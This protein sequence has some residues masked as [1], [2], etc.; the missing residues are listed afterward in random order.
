M[1][2]ILSRHEWWLLVVW[3]LWRDWSH[4]ASLL[5]IFKTILVFR[6]IIKLNRGSKF[7]SFWHRLCLELHNFLILTNLLNHRGVLGFRYNLHWV[8]YAQTIR[9]WVVQLSNVIAVGLWGFCRFLSLAALFR[10]ESLQRRCL[11]FRG[12]QLLEWWLGLF[13]CWA[14]FTK[15]VFVDLLSFYFVHDCISVMLINVRVDARRRFLRALVKVLRDISWRLPIMV[16]KVKTI[17]NWFVN[18]VRI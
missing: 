17:H 14:K 8:S 16:L 6:L 10:R 15:L 5:G 1:R 13:W 4:T 9:L 11:R 7:A 18:S 12:A 2:A 3:T